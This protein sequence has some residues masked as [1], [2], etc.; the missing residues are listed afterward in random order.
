MRKRSTLDVLFPRVRSGLLAATFLEPERWW[1]MTELAQ[2]LGT[3][4]SSLQRELDSL[5]EVSLLV[6]RQDGRRIYLKANEAS[7][8]FPDL[9]GLFEKTRGLVPTLTSALDRFRDK[10]VLA[11]L[12]GSI[13]R[14]EENATS[15]VDLL[16]VGSIKQIDLLPSLRKLESRFHREVNITFFAPE[17][18][19]RRLKAKDHF[20]HTVLKAK[21]LR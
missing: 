6:R 1:F 12:Y 11:M 21:T 3:A 7:P 19:E 14:G 17:E 9:K 15:D 8:L 4:P 13:A 16:L 5:V 20:L 2:H 18:F 10:I